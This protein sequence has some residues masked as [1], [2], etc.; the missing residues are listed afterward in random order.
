MFHFKV[1][2]ILIILEEGSSAY[3]QCR[4][5]GLQIVLILI[6]LEEGSSVFIL[7]LDCRNKP[8]S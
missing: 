3:Y 7:L 2:L 5:P 1:V 6:I 8:M 4:I